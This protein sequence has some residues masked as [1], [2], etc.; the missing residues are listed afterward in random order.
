MATSGSSL[1]NSAANTLSNAG[2]ILSSNIARGLHL[3]NGP[4]PRPL[5]PNPYIP[6]SISPES[7]LSYSY[8]K[9]GLVPGFPSVPSLNESFLNPSHFMQDFQR[10]ELIARQELLCRQELSRNELSRSSFIRPEV[11]SHELILRHHELSRPLAHR[12][13]SR[14]SV[15]KDL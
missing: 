8:A 9:A 10:H 4:Y 1:S 2:R 5:F 3:D 11:S 7:L 13:E 14:S 12:L 15:E 6:S